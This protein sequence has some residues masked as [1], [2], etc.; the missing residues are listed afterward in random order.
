MAGLSTNL[1][2]HVVS[3]SVLRVA[4]M[5]VLTP[6]APCL[7]TSSKK[8]ARSAMCLICSSQRSW[9][10]ALHA[11]RNDTRVSPMLCLMAV[12]RMTNGQG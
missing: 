10:M 3:F 4:V 2:R 11:A 12:E 8:S 1:K 7:S 6:G 5:F 9:Y